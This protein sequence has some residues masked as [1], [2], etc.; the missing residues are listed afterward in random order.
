M[1]VN[2]KMTAI[3]DEIRTLSGTTD[4]MGLDAMATNVSNANE[5]IA[6]QEALMEQLRSALEG[7]SVGGGGGS[8]SG[9]QF[10]QCKPEDGLEIPLPDHNIF[11]YMLIVMF[12][13]YTESFDNVPTLV[14]YQYDKNSD[15]GRWT[16][17][18]IGLG[19]AFE[20][21]IDSAESVLKFKSSDPSADIS[22]VYYC[23]LYVPRPISTT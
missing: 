8:S 19:A 7:K 6:D 13:S 5:E 16:R 17:T 9:L 15:S 18:S 14:H 23:N 12:G 22:T 2:T 3:A 11:N 4:P 10:I 1:S 20:L 21:S